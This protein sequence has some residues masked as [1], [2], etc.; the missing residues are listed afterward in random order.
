MLALTLGHGQTFKCVGNQEQA[1][2]WLGW[3]LAGERSYDFT[4]YT[5]GISV[6]L[7]LRSGYLEP[8]HSY[9]ED[10][11][12]QHSAE[13]NDS[14][15]AGFLFTFEICERLIYFSYWRQRQVAASVP[16]GEMMSQWS[17]RATLFGRPASSE[18]TNVWVLVVIGM[19]DHG[20][21]IVV[22]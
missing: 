20:I 17:D 13:Y 12:Q 8:R 3:L 14:L 11:E 16:D 6:P 5:C 7:T 4:K 21:L 19:M 10:L 22:S 1:C 15:S 18:V 9:V 2:D